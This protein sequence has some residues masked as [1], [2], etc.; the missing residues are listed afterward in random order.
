VQDVLA[1]HDHLTKQRNEA[2][3]VAG[4]MV[5]GTNLAARQASGKSLL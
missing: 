4:A 3:V 1:M 2:L 5:V